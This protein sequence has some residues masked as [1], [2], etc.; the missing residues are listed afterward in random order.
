[1]KVTVLS[2]KIIAAC[3]AKIARIDE[4][5]ADWREAAILAIMSERP[6]RIARL[7]GAHQKSR[8]EAEKWAKEQEINGH[9]DWVNIRED[10]RRDCAVIM[11]MAKNCPEMTLN[12]SEF[13]RAGLRNME[14]K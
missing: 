1:M 4:L 3:K 8:F 9:A 12:E 5:R 10:S 2:E 13:V 7:F 6:S 11:E 14:Q